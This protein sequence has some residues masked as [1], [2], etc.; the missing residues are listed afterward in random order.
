MRRITIYIIA[1]TFIFLIIIFSFLYIF[2]VYE[3]TYSVI[4]R[5]LYADSKSTVTISIKPVNA[6]GWKTPFRNAT[7]NLIIKN[8][9][10]LIDILS[11][12]INK[13]ILILRAKNKQGKIIVY[14][15]SDY[16]LLPS[17]L[18]INILPE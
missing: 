3:V 13:G 16:A 4:P 7:A 10:E 5:N 18:E 1:G 9:K 6:F 15:K 12:D 11:E 17:T 2:N 8:G 14:I